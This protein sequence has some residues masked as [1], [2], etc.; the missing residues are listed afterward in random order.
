MKLMINVIHDDGWG[1]GFLKDYVRYAVGEAPSGRRR[2]LL[3]GK[4]GTT[5]YPMGSFKLLEH[6]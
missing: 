6:G 3:F 1:T 4:A 5:P 2:M